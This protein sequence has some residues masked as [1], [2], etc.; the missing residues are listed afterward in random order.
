MRKERGTVLHS[1][2]LRMAVRLIV[3]AAWTVAQLAGSAYGDTRY[4]QHSFFDNSLTPGAYY[5]S[6]GKASA[7]SVL[8][9]VNGRVPVEGKTAL[10]P[11]NAL[12]LEWQ[13]A[14]N[15]GWE[16][17]VDVVRF[18]NREIQFHGDTLSFWC[19]S[20]QRLTASALPLI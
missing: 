13:S 4:Y 6:S 16:A 2:V 5:Y 10:T 7:P 19:F 8:T 9:L 3:G 11:P 1:F 15:G 17:R 18:R 12:R 14:E 20:P